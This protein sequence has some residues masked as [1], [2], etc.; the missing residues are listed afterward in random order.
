MMNFEQLDEQLR[1]TFADLRLSDDES[2]KLRQLGSILDVERI[3]FLRNRAFVMVREIILTDQD[4]ALPALKWLE[5]VVKTLDLCIQQQRIEASAYFTPG[6]DCLN[7]IRALCRGARHSIDVCVF[8]ISDNRISE[9]L[10]SAKRRGVQVRIITDNDKQ[11]DIGSDIE[12]LIQANISVCT[13]NSEYHMH[14]KFALFDR[15]ILLNG[16]FNWT[17]SA[18]SS[19]EE[20]LLTTDNPALVKQYITQFEKLWGMFWAAS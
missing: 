14:H 2:H 4:K 6:D 20:N 10:I 9:E 11:Y 19:N 1:D 3:R 18:S 12:E 7:K 5:Q 13:D 16:S 15:K 8:T 17:R